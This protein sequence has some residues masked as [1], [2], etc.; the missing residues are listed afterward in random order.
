MYVKQHVGV[1]LNEAW[2]A[3]WGLTHRLKRLGHLA[4]GS[5]G[6]R[7]PL[8]DALHLFV[9]AVLTGRHQHA[10]GIKEERRAVHVISASPT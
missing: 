1:S 9:D 5:P 7:L 3:W 6:P 2:V 8:L 4:N 10:G